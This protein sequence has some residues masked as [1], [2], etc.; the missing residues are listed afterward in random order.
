MVCFH[1][2]ENDWSTWQLAGW[3]ATGG[4]SVLA[5]GPGPL[6]AFG[7]QHLIGPVFR[8]GGRPAWP[9]GLG[10]PRSAEPSP[11]SGTRP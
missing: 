2:T 7:K 8:S 10:S 6:V 3:L 4:L 11:P 5:E 9:A 1:E